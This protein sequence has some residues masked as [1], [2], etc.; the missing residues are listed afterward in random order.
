MQVTHILNINELPTNIHSH[1]RNKKLN[2]FKVFAIQ[3]FFF[4]VESGT[5]LIIDIFF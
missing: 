5:V 1:R 4:V 2:I 3:T